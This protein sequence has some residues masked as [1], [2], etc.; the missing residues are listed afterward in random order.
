MDAAPMTGGLALEDDFFLPEPPEYSWVRE[1]TSFWIF[2]DDG[3]FGIPRIGVEAEPVSWENRRYQ[4]NFAFK[5][6]RVLQ[7][8][9]AGT[10]HPVIDDSGR[11]A[12]LGAGPITFR[13]VEPFRRWQVGFDGAASDTHLTNQ[14]AGQLQG[15]P[16]I[17]LRYEIELEM[18]VPAFLQDCRPEAFFRRGKGEQRDGLSV[19]LGWRIEQLF[20]GAG[21]LEVDGTR[22]DFSAS[23]MRVKRRSVRT[24]GLFLRGHCW[25]TA[26]FPDGRAFGYLAYPPHDDG[27]AP[28]NQGFIWQDGRMYPAKAR[29]MPWLRRVTASGDDVSLELESELGVTRIA[30]TT[31]LSTCRVSSKEMWGLDLQQSG[32]R[33]EWDGQTAYGMIERSARPDQ[34]VIEA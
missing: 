17:P 18:V 33:Y 11:P 24:D 15:A 21:W 20:K 32:V 28:W 10:M 12:V 7:D 1:G 19:G 9:G 13:C 14:I 16:R 2:A 6:G 29:N 30:G 3:S 34:T 23:G 4:A 26:V 31:T 22:R 8:A 5:D 25:Q 27:H